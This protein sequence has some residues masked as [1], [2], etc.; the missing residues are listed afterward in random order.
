MDIQ[1]H[2][3]RTNW[4]CH[5]KNRKTTERPTTVSKTL[6]DQNEHNENPA[7]NSVAPKANFI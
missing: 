1:S 2:M 5:G 3:S 6:S 7:V 4:Q